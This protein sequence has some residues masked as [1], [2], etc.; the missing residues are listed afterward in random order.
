MYVRK[1]PDSAYKPQYT[2]KT[3]KHGRAKINIWGCFSYYGVG[4]IYKTDG[5]MDQDIYLQI[6]QNTM[7]PYAEED[8]PLRWVYMQDNDPKHTSRRVKS[9]FIENKVAVT[10]SQSERKPLDGCKRPFIVKNQKISRS[11]G[12]LSRMLGTTFL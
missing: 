2:I 3:V 11:Y 4:P 8:M 12:K 7:L 6:L 1:P 9:W 5:I 10:G